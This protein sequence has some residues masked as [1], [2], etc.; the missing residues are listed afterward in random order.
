[1]SVLGGPRF[2]VAAEPSFGGCR[3]ATPTSVMSHTSAMSYRP[4][5]LLGFPQMSAEKTFSAPS[6]NIIRSH[7]KRQQP[8]VK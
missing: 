5:R 6:A 8:G 7:L 4:P 1:M 2:V 3:V